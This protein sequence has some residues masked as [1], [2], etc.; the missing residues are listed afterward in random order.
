MLASNQIVIDTVVNNY[1]DHL[2]LYR[3]SAMLERDTGVGVSRAMLDGWVRQVG[4]LL[5]PLVG[6]MRK[7]LLRGSYVQADETPVEV[8]MHQGRGKNHQ[9]YPWQY[10]RPGGNVIFD[11]RLSRGRDGPR[12]FLG[13]FDGILQTDGYAAVRHEVDSAIVQPGISMT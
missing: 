2:P 5:T 3:Q 4:E 13:Q 9:A 12:E 1:C 8:Q 10:G 11:F 7:D 6:A